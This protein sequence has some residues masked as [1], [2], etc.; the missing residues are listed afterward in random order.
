MDWQGLDHWP[1]YSLNSSSAQT[2]GPSHNIE[3]LF[4]GYKDKW[5]SDWPGIGT[6]FVWIGMDDK[7]L[8]P[9]SIPCQSTTRQFILNSSSEQTRDHTI[10]ST[11]SLVIQTNVLVNGTGL[12][13]DWLGLAWI[14]MDWNGVAE[15]GK[16]EN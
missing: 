14:G 7:E 1:M 9:V 5:A 2:K 6:G 10:Q 15:I 4:L 8:D 12:A 11:C 16:L 13:L 3:H